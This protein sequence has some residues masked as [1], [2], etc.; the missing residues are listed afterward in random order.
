MD[1]G[2][3]VLQDA[4]IKF[5]VYTS[6]NIEKIPYLAYHLSPSQLLETKAIATVLPFR[7]NTYVLDHLIDWDNVPNDPVYQIVF[8]QPG[9]LTEEDTNKIKNAIILDPSNKEKIK[10]LAN[11][12]RN[13]LNPHPSD[14]MQLNIPDVGNDGYKGIQHKYKETALFFPAQGQTCHTYCAFCFRW[15]Q[16]TDNKNLRFSDPNRDILHQYLLDNK[17]VSNLILT[18]G[19]PMVMKSSHFEYYLDALS[20]SKY[21]HLQTIRIGTKSLTYWPY[22]FTHD[23]DADNLLRLFEKLISSGKHITI[24]AHYNHVNE[25][26]TDVALLA[27]KRLQNTGVII[28]SQGPILN[29]VNNS[30]DIWLDLWN[31]QERLGII[32]YYMFVERQTGSYRYY[33]VP[34]QKAYEVYRNALCQ[35]SGL[36]RTVR[37]PSMSTTNGK[38]EIQGITQIQNK[39]VFVLRYIQASNPEWVQRPFFAHFNDKAT[40]FDQLKPFY[41]EDAF[42]FK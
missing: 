39:K 6:A 32:P 25:L 38:V 41:P 1:D 10:L 36:V 27:I 33:E 26:Q 15:A 40:W 14:Q 3:T 9:M 11:E 8:P 30:S 21:N 16:F 24:M 37:G 42:F 23:S 18:G 2:S 31:K 4:N 17:S 35:T 12:I 22:R 29:H 20:Q 34:L 28:R 13:K 19:D 7:V 5:I